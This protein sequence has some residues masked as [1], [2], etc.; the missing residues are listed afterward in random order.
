MLLIHGNV[1]LASWPAVVEPEL[2]VQFPQKSEAL[3]EIRVPLPFVPVNIASVSRFPNRSFA[4]SL[5]LT[6]FSI[7][8]DASHS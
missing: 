5:Y 4:Y 7:V 6:A 8:Y 3:L 2:D 1:A